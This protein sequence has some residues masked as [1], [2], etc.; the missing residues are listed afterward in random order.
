MTQATVKLAI[1]VRV[2]R[3]L[4]KFTS[5]QDW[6]NRAKRLFAN[7]GVRQGFYISI[8]VNGHVMHIGKCFMAAEQFNSYPV[9]VYELQTNWE[10]G[11]A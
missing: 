7:C 3:E 10:G 6:V 2:K 4:F 8:D 11:A 5:Q 9:T 1:P